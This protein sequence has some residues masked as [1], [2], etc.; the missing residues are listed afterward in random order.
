LTV[1]VWK[2]AV[3]AFFK[4]TSHIRWDRTGKAKKKKKVNRNFR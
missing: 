1:N 2:E 3:V 4:M